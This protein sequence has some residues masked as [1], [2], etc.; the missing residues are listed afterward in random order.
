MKNLTN[1]HKKLDRLIAKIDAVEEKPS[2][3][4]TRR[5]QAQYFARMRVLFRQ[6][7]EHTREV[8]AD[9][10]RMRREALSAARAS[11]KRTAAILVKLRKHE[12]RGKRK[13]MYTLVML[14]LLLPFT[15]VAQ[16]P[17]QELYPEKGSL[18]VPGGLKMKKHPDGSI[19]VYG[20][21]SIDT[22]KDGPVSIEIESVDPEKGTYRAKPGPKEPPQLDVAPGVPQVPDPRR[23]GGKPDVLELPEPH[24][25]LP[26]ESFLRPV[27]YWR[28][29]NWWH[30]LSLVGIDAFKIKC[31]ALQQQLSYWSGTFGTKGINWYYDTLDS[32]RPTYGGTYWWLEGTWDDKIFANW[33]WYEQWQPCHAYTARFYNVDF[34]PLVSAPRLFND[35]TWLQLKTQICARD[36]QFLDYWYW[37]WRGGPY[38]SALGVL[39]YT[40]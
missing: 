21:G 23:P 1:V 22:A 19:E 35:R 38:S 15:A 12:L 36:E 11:S 16:P 18:A 30:A 6:M 39:V 20:H 9:V 32:G 31:V 24:S 3:A 5:Q 4:R 28:A 37:Y 27:D 17:E 8:Q 7:V 34:P 14:L 33:S 40:Q 29:G 25:A 10:A 2:T 26:G 13:D